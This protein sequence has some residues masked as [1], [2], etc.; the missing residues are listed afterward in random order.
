MNY[1]DLDKQLEE[2]LRA[3]G[4]IYRLAQDGLSIQTTIGNR[5]PVSDI[6]RIDN[7]DLEYTVPNAVYMNKGIRF[8]D[9]MLFAGN[10]P[11]FAMGTVNKDAKGHMPPIIAMGEFH[12]SVLHND[13][14]L[15]F[16][17]ADKIDV[18][19]I[20]NGTKWNIYFDSLPEACFHLYV[21]LAGDYGIVATLDVTGVTA[22]E[23]IQLVCN[24][25]EAR[26]GDHVPTYF[27]ENCR[28]I[29]TKY[30]IECNEKNVLIQSESDDFEYRRKAA[31]L[32]CCASVPEVDTSDFIRIKCDIKSCGNVLTISGIHSPLCENPD[33]HKLNEDVYKVIDDSE[34]QFKRLLDRASQHTCEPLLD[35]GF[36]WSVLNLEYV[37]VSPAWLEGGQ[38]WNSR[39]TNNY[40]ISAAISI[41]QYEYAAK[42]FHYFAGL[43]DGYSIIALDGES[44]DRWTKKDGTKA[45]GF[46]GIPYY[47]YQL[48][49][50]TN[51]T[52]DFS[53]L[54]ETAPQIYAMCRD[55]MEVCDPDNDGLLSWKEGCNAF[56]YQADHLSVPGAGFSPSVMMAGNYERYAELLD[57][58]GEKNLA[59]EYF[60][61][62]QKIYS[63]L[64]RLWDEERGYFYS[65]I[66]LTGTPCTTHFYTDLV[67]PVLYAPKLDDYRKILPLMHLK[68]SLLY[69]SAQTDGLLM[70]MGE[71]KPNLFGNNYVQ[72]VQ[73]AEAARAFFAIGD[74]KTGYELLC[75]CGYAMSIFTENPGS[76]P[77]KLNW[78][79]KGEA[80]YMF[81]NP[82]A[83]FA[84]AVVSGLMGVTLENSG[85]TMV[86]AP[87][88]PLDMPQWQYNTPYVSVSF[89]N[90]MCESGTLRYNITL[91]RETHDEQR[92]V[93]EEVVFSLFIPHTDGIQ[94]AENLYITIF[95]KPVEFSIAPGLHSHKITVSIPV[96]DISDFQMA[97][98]FDK[99]FCLVKLPAEQV[100][101]D[102]TVNVKKGDKYVLPC[103]NNQQ[104]LGDSPDTFS[105]TGTF[106]RMY[107]DKDAKVYGLI[108]I[109]VADS[110]PARTI[111]GKLPIAL[112]ESLDIKEI[113]NANGIRA[114]N[115]WRYGGEFRMFPSE[116]N[117]DG[118]YA[119]IST[120]D[121]IYKCIC[122]QDGSV[123]VCRLSY[124]ISDI[125]NGCIVRSEQ[126]NS[127]SIQVH[128]AVSAVSLLYLSEVCVW[129][130]GENQQLGKIQ[131]CYEDGYVDT[132]PLVS[133]DNMGSILGNYSE[134][135]Y[136]VPL[137]SHLK[138]SASHYCISCDNNK[139]LKCIQISIDKED[140]E[141]GLAGVSYS[142]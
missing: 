5:Y 86:V 74:Y 90:N 108:Q 56:L 44:L 46:D 38:W 40:Q 105:G 58:A 103:E 121:S 3:A 69:R 89:V 19:F 78:H 36:S 30:T 96:V 49:Q 132:I 120:H 87:G 118:E 116:Q 28:K 72:P 94:L 64:D 77:E 9:T 59:K 104:L 55:M 135:T 57:F 39:F 37:H 92:S 60:D 6:I 102:K 109:N 32:L 21:S 99:P 93:V 91:P 33:L 124:G 134:N 20:P 2:K 7:V 13:K 97:L 122:N 27:S 98:K 114:V 4:V 137:R 85:K 43:P 54:T 81:G 112:T 14:E 127:V 34:K 16:D 63:A 142:L 22:C 47:I 23:N 111:A 70:R 48:I 42:A 12:F 45:L 61:Y 100:F 68:D 129:L 24:I 101:T 50:Y 53:V 67:F 83:S 84:Y 29:D 80:D 41:G 11:C 123:R 15:F 125:V 25:K 66:D 52:G 73:M 88:Y 117:I 95:D 17:S 141:F 115:A 133:G 110:R 136:K 76:A 139:I 10:L 26:I 107:Y 82:A 130:S 62:A 140:V 106:Y 1:L 18:T 119:V 128:K 35:A 131:L 126:P 71:H 31:Y 79:G 75:S 51:H 65:C 138:D 113:L 8:E